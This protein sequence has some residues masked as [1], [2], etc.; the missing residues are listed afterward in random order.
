MPPLLMWTT[1]QS[2]KHNVRQLKIKTELMYCLDM[3][4]Q[5]LTLIPKER[6]KI[7]LLTDGGRVE[8]L[9]RVFH[10]LCKILLLQTGSAHVALPHQDITCFPSKTYHYISDGLAA[11][12]VL[13]SLMPQSAVLMHIQSFSMSDSLYITCIVC[14]YMG[15]HSTELKNAQPHCI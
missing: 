8:G 9:A 2:Q 5:T 7:K 13:E 11:L 15:S 6:G 14:L 10:R 4:N 12:I 3:T 1:L